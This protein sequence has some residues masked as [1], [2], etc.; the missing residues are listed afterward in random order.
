MIAPEFLIDKKTPWS[1][2]KIST[3]ELTACDLVRYMDSSGQIHAVATVLF[4]LAEK[5]NVARLI[6]LFN[7]KIVILYVLQRLGYILEKSETSLNLEPLAEL[8]NQNKPRYIALVG[9]KKAVIEKNS[10]WHILV[11][12][13]IEL[14]EI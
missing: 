11:D 1:Y 10:R 5:I 7:K 8:I 13:I 3:V 6:E 4:E 14:D 2:F 9:R 12:E